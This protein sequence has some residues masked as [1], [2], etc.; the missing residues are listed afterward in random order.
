MSAK[1]AQIFDRETLPGF[2]VKSLSE[3]REENMK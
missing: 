2:H 3:Q 1:T